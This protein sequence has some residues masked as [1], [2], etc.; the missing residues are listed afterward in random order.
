MMPLAQRVETLA[1]T[2]PTEIAFHGDG[3]ALCWRDYAQRADY[4][5]ARLLSAGLKRGERVAVLLPDGPGVHIA[6]LACE[7]AGLIVMGIGPRAG[8]DEVRHLI[9]RSG[10][11]ALLSGRMHRG[12]DLSALCAELR[13][14]GHPLAFEFRAEAG[15]GAEDGLV[16]ADQTMPLPEPARALASDEIFLLNSTSGTTGLPKC[17]AHDQDRWFA[18]HEPATRNAELGPEDIFL[19][20]LP[21]PFGFGLWTAHF[22]PTLLGIPCVVPAAFSPEAVLRAIAHHRVTVLAAVSTQFILMLESPAFATA[23]LSSLRILFTGGEAVPFERAAAFEERSG[24]AVL[25]FYGSNEAGALSGTTTRDTREKRLRPAG[26]PIANMNVRLFDDSGADVTASGRG[27]PGCRGPQISRGYWDDDAANTELFRKDGWMLTGD[28]AEIDADGYLSIVGRTADIIIRGGKNLSGP[29]IEAEAQTHPSIRLAAAVAMP[30]PIFGERVC[31]FVETNDGS[32]LALADLKA[33]LA[34][35][36]VSKEWWPERLV[37]KEL[38]PLS[39]GG[40]VAKGV[41]RAEARELPAL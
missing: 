23:D 30:D 14:E 28:I 3:E 33:H 17:V 11:R 21:A 34:A 26:R 2:R 16:Q 13:R 41:L 4:L 32:S 15:L 25:Q 24:A 22:T 19:S 9:R 40:K 39:S 35:R 36:G 27:Q 6:Y 12:L 31:L 5:A 10:A 38:L 37:I 7:K 8:P 20:A 1:R 29:A 18:F